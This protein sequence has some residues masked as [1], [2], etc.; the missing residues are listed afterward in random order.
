MGMFSRKFGHGKVSN[1]SNTKLKIENGKL[2]VSLIDSVT[3]KPVSIH[4]Y[5]ESDF[6]TRYVELR[7]SEYR[8]AKLANTHRLLIQNKITIT[9]IGYMGDRQVVGSFSWSAESKLHN[10]FNR[11]LSHGHLNRV[12]R[13]LVAVDAEVD[14]GC[15]SRPFSDIRD[16]F[17]VQCSGCL[18]DVGVWDAHEAF[19]HACF[20]VVGVFD[21]YAEH[22]KPY[23]N[24]FKLVCDRCGNRLKYTLKITVDFPKTGAGMI[25]AYRFWKNP[26]LEL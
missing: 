10:D 25:K 18:K 8:T 7:T 19:N 14:G 4:Y 5:D 12:Y 2:I 20:S 9:L 26:E 21:G 22:V 16:A 6:L 23:E 24:T 13:G 17:L 3:R 11:R 1:V 15:F